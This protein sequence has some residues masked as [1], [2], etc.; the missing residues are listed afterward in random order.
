MKIK[1]TSPVLIT[2][3]S[4]KIIIN[5]PNIFILDIDVSKLH[6]SNNI[7]FYNNE[8]WVECAFINL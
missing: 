4:K 7:F 1:H 6:Y 3:M 2:I 8:T 5:T